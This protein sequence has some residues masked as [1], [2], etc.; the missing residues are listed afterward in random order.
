MKILTILFSLIISNAH[1]DVK[2]PYEQYLKGK[3]IIIDVREEDEVKEGMIKG[4]HWIPLSRIEKDKKNEIEGIKNL[5]SNKN[6]FLYCRSGKRSGKVQSYLNDSG[7]KSS[8]IG[9]FSEL[10]SAGFPTQLK[11]K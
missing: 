8:N 5:A 1:A 6:I 7:I 9:G 11:S 10:V 4:A 2:E 3:A